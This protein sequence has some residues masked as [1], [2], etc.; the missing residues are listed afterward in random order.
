[1]TEG[2]GWFIMVAIAAFIFCS[3]ILYGTSRQVSDFQDARI[4]CNNKLNTF[5]YVYN[6]GSGYTHPE[7]TCK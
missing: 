6:S 1:M 4:A 7:F 3:L 5:H 2:Q